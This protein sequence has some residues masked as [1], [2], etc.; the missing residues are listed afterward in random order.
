MLALG[1]EGTAHTI[2]ASVLDENKIYSMVSHTYKPANGGINP[3]ETADHHFQYAPI[4]IKKAIEEAGIRP[5]DIQLVCFSRGPGLPPSLKITA[6][7][8]RAFALKYNVPIV[9][10]NHP[11][12]HVEIGRRL[13][14][15]YD[16]VMLYVS[17]GNT[18]I[19]AH[20]ADHY[21]VLGE[22]LDIGI[23]NMIDK[24][25]RALNIPF[26]AGPE[27]EKLAEKGKKLLKIPYSV[28]GMDVAFSGIYTA[29]VSL[30]GKGERPEDVAFSVQETSF[31]MVVEILE[32]ALFTSG[33]GEILTAG[34]VA[35]NR[36]L[37]QMI[38]DMAKEHGVRVFDTPLEYCMDNGA[39]IGQAGLLISKYSGFQ[40]IED[41]AIDQY[42]RIDEVKTPW[43]EDKNTKYRMKGAESIISIEEIK[44][45]ICIKKS[46]PQK[47]YRTE[48]LDNMIRKSRMRN[49]ISMLFQMRSAG[50]NAP[51]PLKIYDDISYAAEYID[52]KQASLLK[53]IEMEKCLNDAGEQAGKMHQAN[54]CHGDLTLNNILY[55]DEK[56]YFIDPSMGKKTEDITE[57]AYDI[58]LMKESLKSKYEE[59]EKFF[60]IFLKSYVKCYR[61]GEKVIEEMK[62]IEERRRYA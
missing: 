50:V 48:E 46:R 43:I 62:K 17:G 18:Q 47:M 28:R 5:E 23:G 38:T 22:T 45:L 33:K 58:R 21:S 1:I 11:L 16:P 20:M 26:P 32:R 34:G 36:R 35:R 29:A 15:A 6:A 39:M 51:L 12:G 14:G 40:K 37:N 2:S 31:S 19:I 53:G 61:D 44:G 55:K 42:Y 41:T 27:I 3:R 30:I 60:K 8:A 54:L 9:G 13:S 10:V 59:W 57:K 25:G 56:S 7:S 52:G 4:V 49:E 24:L